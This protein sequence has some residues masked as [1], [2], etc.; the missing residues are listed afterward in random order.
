MN[1]LVRLRQLETLKCCRKFSQP[2][3]TG[4]AEETRKGKAA[5]L[6]QLDPKVSNDLDNGLYHPRHH[7]GAV[8]RK[9]DEIPESMARAMEILT[10]GMKKNRLVEAGQTFLRQLWG[11]LI[12]PGEDYYRAH[13]KAEKQRTEEFLAE[14]EGELDGVD[15]EH[16]SKVKEKLVVRKLQDKIHPWHPLSDSKETCLQY[17]LF[18]TPAEFCILHKIFSELQNIDP[19]FCPST[20]FDF[21]AGVASGYWAVSEVWKQPLQEVYNV[22]SNLKMIELARNVLKICKMEHEAAKGVYFRQFFPYAS[23]RTYNLALSAFT[24]L[25][26]PSFKERMEAVSLLWEMTDGYLVIVEDGTNAG[27]QAVMEARN[28]IIYLERSD[29]NVSK[30][31]GHLVAPC[32]HDFG[33]PR[34]NFD[35]IPCNFPISYLPPRFLEG[36]QVRKNH[37]YSYAIFKK[38]PRPSSDPQWSRCVRETIALRRAQ[39]LRLCTSKG[40]LEDVIIRKKFNCRNSYQC[41]KYTSW[42]DRVPGKIEDFDAD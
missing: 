6:L 4:K 23:E 24:L 21:G 7:P 29:D 19:D 15:E 18:R 30:R 22:E 36:K 1:G 20:M 40:Q 35:K 10:E 33:C 3:A 8:E 2:S 39:L 31:G 37:L 34:F 38:G 27:Y 26:L 13:I 42:G 28:L 16:I 11:R 41:A 32:P 9:A 12:P 5:K 25:E 17:L 14:M